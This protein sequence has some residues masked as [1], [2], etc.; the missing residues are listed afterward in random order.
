MKIHGM[1]VVIVMMV[2]G[3]LGG[4]MVMVVATETVF[5]SCG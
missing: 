2:R 4:R 3:H 5:S 1:V